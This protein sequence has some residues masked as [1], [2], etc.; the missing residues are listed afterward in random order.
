[1]SNPKYKVHFVGRVCTDNSKDKSVFANAFE[2][3]HDSNALPLEEDDPF[4]PTTLGDII[5]AN[6]GRPFS[7]TGKGTGRSIV[8][9]IKLRY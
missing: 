5:V 7:P 6:F 1:M 2:V 4:P 3:L 8:E 9:Q